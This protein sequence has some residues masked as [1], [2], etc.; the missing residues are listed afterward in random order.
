[1]LT[2]IRL[3]LLTDFLHRLYGDIDKAIEEVAYLLNDDKND[4]HPEFW[5]LWLRRYQMLKDSKEVQITMLRE[6]GHSYRQ[7]QQLLGVSPNTV[8]RVLS[9]YKLKYGALEDTHK[10]KK[11]LHEVGERLARGGRKI[12]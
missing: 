11:K 9:S 8:N 1:M 3:Y 2:E 6:A 5:N 10:L 12:W 7:I 4:L